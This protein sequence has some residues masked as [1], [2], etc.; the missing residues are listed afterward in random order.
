MRI[1]LT[2]GGTGGHIYPN[3]AL[4]PK[5][6]EHFEQILYIGENGGMEQDIAKNNGVEFCGI[7]CAKLRRSFTPKNL[8]I[9]FKLIKSVNETKK[10]LIN[11]K[12]DV[13]FSKGGYVS[14]PVCIA[15]HKLKIPVVVH[16]SDFSFGLANRLSIKYA[17]KVLTSFPIE[18]YSNNDEFIFCGAPIRDEVLKA[19]PFKV[20]SNQKPTVLIVGGSSGAQSL[21]KLVK[22]EL[23]EILK[24]F[25]VIHLCGKN[26]IDKTITADRYKQLEFSNQMGELIKGA[27]LVVSRGGANAL[28]EI[29]L[30]KKPSLVVPLSNRS[31]RGDQIENANYFAKKELIKLYDEN[32]SLS[33]QLN[34]L[35]KN[36]KKYIDNLNNCGL[37]DGKDRIINA[38]LSVLP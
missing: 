23:T 6:R 4:L 27:D 28:F 33:S 16:E 20:F 35:Y 15:A 13:I 21:N 19:T 22:D 5:L 17:K 10:I 9:P 8:L 34:F 2:G 29:I 11:F 26:K 36:K 14:L 25:N 37:K 24:T 31:S 30:L 7:D 32:L 1:A 3:I 12:P 38:I 18:N